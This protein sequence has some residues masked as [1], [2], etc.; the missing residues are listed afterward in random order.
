V[1]ILSLDEVDRLLAGGSLVT[2]TDRHAPVD[3]LLAPVARDEALH[4]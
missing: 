3:Q 4:P 1:Q 2:L